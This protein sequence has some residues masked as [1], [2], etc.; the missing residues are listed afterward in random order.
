VRTACSPTFSREPTFVANQLRLWTVGFSGPSYSSRT[1][2]C[3]SSA[4]TAF[5]PQ[6]GRILV[7]VLMATLCL[8]WLCTAR[9]YTPTGAFTLSPGGLQTWTEGLPFP[10]FWC[11]DGVP[12]MSTQAGGPG[13][14]AP[15]LPVSTARTNLFASDVPRLYRRLGSPFSGMHP[16][17]SQPQGIFRPSCAH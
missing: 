14:T 4:L 1:G 3:S 13:C 10:N 7:A 8:L 11:L 17:D 2:A 9:L 5:R 6:S 16:P 12:V 15:G